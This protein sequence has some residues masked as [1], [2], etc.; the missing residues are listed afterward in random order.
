[1]MMLGGALCIKLLAVE[2]YPDIAPPAVTVSAVYPG[3]DAQT[4]ENT[5]TQLIEQNLTG[6]DNLIYMKSTS[7]AQGVVQTTLTFA[8][9]TSPD[10]AQVQVL[11]KVESIKS[12]LPES[13]QKNGVSVAKN[14]TNFL[15][16]IGFYSTN[17]QKTQADI[18]DFIYS[19]VQDQIRRVQGV[20]DTQLFG[21][22][23]AMRIWLDPNKLN[24][25]NLSIEEIIAAIQAQN[26]QV[27]AGQLGALPATEGQ[28]LNATITAQSRLKTPEQ[29]LMQQSLPNHV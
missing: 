24:Y 11:N 26:A 27:T 20:G 12:R 13:V 17:P 25:F 28:E 19:T 1:M 14:N 8:P 6:L 2:Q 15:K 4:I 3:A 9:G 22:E 16:V 5:V 23:Y 21:S 18:A 29:F 10:F 7:S